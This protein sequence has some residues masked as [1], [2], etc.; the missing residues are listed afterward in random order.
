MRILVNLARV[1]VGL[2]FIFSGLIKANDPLGLSYKMQEFF[3]LWGLSQFNS[4]TLIM[5]VMMNAFE[6][7]AG[8]ALLIGWG[9]R[10]ISWL[11]LLLILF[12][13]FLTGY[14][15][16]SGQFKNCGCFGDCIPIESKTSFIKDL[17]LLVLIVFIFW[18]QKY[19][20]PVWKTGVS[21]LAMLLATVFSFGLQWYT[22]N[23]LPLFDCLPFKKGNS[24]SEKM[25]IPAGAR[26]DSF[27]ILFVYE[28]GGKQFEFTATELPSD[29]GTY[30]FVSR[31]D[32]LIRKGNAEPAIKGFELSGE[33]NIDSTSFVL[34]QPYALLL[35]C[36]NFKVPVSEWDKQFTPVYEAAVKK[37]I[38]VFLVTSEPELARKNME[39]KAF[40]GVTIFK[41]DFTAI[42][43][44]ARTNPCLYVLKKGTILEKW[45]QHDFGKAEK[46][47]NGLSPVSN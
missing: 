43:T 47:V 39:G 32:K 30:T 42:R 18:Q 4:W 38:P 45:S 11:L 7:I 5:S 10:V 26:P 21:V 15:Y 14:A 3:D 12:F 16:F 2:L 40:S 33:S 6:I 9:T 13:T 44:A 17:I 31:K 23:Y 25:K 46:L 20:K 41:C 27:A 36:E 28:K 24:I 22:L 1:L 8:F 19:I 34:E 35:F 37:N 29:L